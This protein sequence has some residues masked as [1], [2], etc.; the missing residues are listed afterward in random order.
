MRVKT[1]LDLTEWIF[2]NDLGH[3]LH[4]RLKHGQ[5]CARTKKYIKGGFDPSRMP[6]P[7]PWLYKCIIW[8]WSQLHCLSGKKQMFG[9]QNE[10]ALKACNMWN[11]QS[12]SRFWKESA[13]WKNLYAQWTHGLYPP[14]LSG[15][16]GIF[17]NITKLVG[18]I[19][20]KIAVGR[21]FVWII[22]GRMDHFL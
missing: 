15:G 6:K 19:S 21:R 2:F 7:K 14:V 18:W 17:Q 10:F 11:L 4:D 20:F 3:I 13:W 8:S 16:N 12:L 9:S 1:L 22:V 5:Q